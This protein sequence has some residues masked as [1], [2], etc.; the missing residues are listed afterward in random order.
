MIRAG[1]VLP[2]SAP[3]RRLVVP[4]DALRRRWPVAAVAAALVMIAALLLLGTQEPPYRSVAV[5]AVTA[6]EGTAQEDAA[7]ILHAAV[8]GPRAVDV[9][10]LLP[11][12]QAASAAVRVVDAERAS[13]LTIVYEGSTP[14]AALD[15][16][17]ASL[18]VALPMARAALPAG[19]VLRVLEEPSVPLREPR[20]WVSLVVAVAG[21]M[22]VVAALAA[23]VA[24]VA[25]RRTSRP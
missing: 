12:A 7:E 18:S 13:A 3:L 11:G 1:D 19:A 22:A 8:S 10:A 23:L 21:L 25:A 16:A 14:D 6:P 9:D 4:A 20:P 15:L 2:G 5:V 17:T 24:E